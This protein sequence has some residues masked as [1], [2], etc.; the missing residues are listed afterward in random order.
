[1]SE[2]TAEIAEGTPDFRIGEVFRLT[3]SGLFGHFPKFL[4]LGLI[5]TLPTMVLTLVTGVTVS[6]LGYVEPNVAGKSPLIKLAFYVIPLLCY[7]IS[8]AAIYYGTLQGIRER[9]FRLGAGLLRALRRYFALLGTN[10]FYVVAFGVGLILLVIPGLMLAISLS[11]SFPI[12]VVE[13]LGPKDSVNHSAALTKGHRWK[14]FGIFLVI[15]VTGAIAGSLTKIIF[16]AL[17]GTIASTLM[18]SVCDAV[19]YAFNCIATAVIYHD[20]RALK[21]GVEI[22]RIA[23]VFD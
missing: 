1:M 21:E 22:D 4:L 6:A 11:L 9:P 3:F 14:I 2:T 13:G 8:Q 20:L 23:A 7:P 15:V 17:G 19:V 5:A 16:M 12:C 10:L 18:G